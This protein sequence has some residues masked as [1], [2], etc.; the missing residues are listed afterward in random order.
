[1]DQLW[2]VKLGSSF[3]LIIVLAILILVWE[4][5]HKAHFAAEQLIQF[6]DEENL[7][8]LHLQQIERQSIAV[9]ENLSRLATSRANESSKNSNAVAQKEHSHGDPADEVINTLND[10]PASATVDIELI[11]K[12]TQQLYQMEKELNGELRSLEA[13]IQTSARN[14]IIQE[15]GEGPVQVVLDLDFGDDPNPQQQAVTGS[16]KS[17]A[18]ANRIA[19]LLWHDT[20]HAAWTWLEQ[21]G[22]HVWDGADF[23]W[24]QAH[25]IDAAPKKHDPLGNKIEFVEKTQLCGHESWTVGLRNNDSASNGSNGLGMYINLQDNTHLH[26]HETCIGKVLDGFDALQRLLEVSRNRSYDQKTSIKIKSASAMHVTQRE[27]GR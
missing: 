21:I 13:R 26:K 25:V 23:T 19:I 3:Q 11:Q 1:M 7:L 9:H 14:H 12:Q 6:K 2:R 16:K 18:S 22:R 20:P 5:H 10:T 15:F 24:Q 17:K 8:M 4:S 27:V